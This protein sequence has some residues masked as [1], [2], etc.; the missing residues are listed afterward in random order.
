MAV[1]LSVEFIYT[2][3]PHGSE[4]LAGGPGSGRH[5]M[6]LSKAFNVGG[7]KKVGA[8]AGSN[9]GGV[10]Q[11][12]QGSEK[13]YI[14]FP[15]KNPEQANAEVLAD[16]IYRHLDLPAKESYLVHNNGQLG[17]ASKL[18][19]GA[20]NMS[21]KEISE[22]KHALAGY[23]ADAY[24]ANWD[25]FGLGWDNFVK[26]PTTGDAHRIDTGGALNFRAQGGDKPFAKDAVLELLSLRQPDK[27]GHG[28]WQHLSTKDEKAQA[29]KLVNKLDLATISK[30]AD[31]AGYSGQKKAEIVA[32]L[33]GRRNVIAN[34]YG[35]KK[36]D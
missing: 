6:G 34:K 10:Y 24:L 30:F 36:E 35:V 20:K 27:Q 26:H 13:V 32:A 29:Q 25:V 12:P 14:K 33:I 5:P 17:V 3:T 21:Q 18:I 19:E 8:Q 22:H 11:H 7:W 1:G 15:Q 9:P 16:K 2:P 23:I 31:E 4:L 28:V